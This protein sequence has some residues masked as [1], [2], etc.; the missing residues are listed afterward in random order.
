MTSSLSK[1]VFFTAGAF[2]PAADL[3]TPGVP[4]AYA[5][6]E[7]D[8]NCQQQGFVPEKCFVYSGVVGAL[9][10]STTR[11]RRGPVAP[12]TRKLPVVSENDIRRAAE[13]L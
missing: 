5:K 9:T 3:P 12:V 6:H 4:L 1:N 2:L 7:M 11:D 13:M 8:V 10:A